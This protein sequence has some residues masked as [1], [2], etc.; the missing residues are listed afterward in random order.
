MSMDAKTL[1]ITKQHVCL[2]SGNLTKD[3]M[4]QYMMVHDSNSTIMYDGTWW[5]MTA[6][7]TAYQKQVT[8]LR[9]QVSFSRGNPKDQL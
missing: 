2:F 5:Y 3:S 6:G 7:E 9:Q 1:N 8:S 4:V